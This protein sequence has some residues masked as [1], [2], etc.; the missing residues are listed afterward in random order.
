MGWKI[1]PSPR[2]LE[3][4]DLVEA[5]WPG[6]PSVDVEH[7]DLLAWC[8]DGG[9]AGLA[10][11]DDGYQVWKLRPLRGRAYNHVQA[12]SGP[13]SDTEAFRLALVEAPGLKLRWV[14]LPGGLRGL[15]DESIDMIEG[16]LLE[17]DRFEVPLPILATIDTGNGVERDKVRQD[18]LL[19]S[20]FQ[21]LATQI[22]TAS[23]RERR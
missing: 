17:R 14:T 2:Q 21:A 16:Y 9:S 10:Y 19:T 11:K 8:I 4:H 15:A 5:V 6:D 1:K 20:F 13:A 3:P 23:F 22:L 7:S 18:L 12:I